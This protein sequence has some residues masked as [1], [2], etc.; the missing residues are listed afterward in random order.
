MKR[1]N[2]RGQALVEFAIVVPVF[3][4]LLAGMIQFGIILWGQNTLNQVVRD[5]GRYAATLCTDATRLTVPT[6]FGTL[7]TQ[8]G[9]PWTGGTAA[10]TYTSTSCPPDKNT[11]HWVTVVGTANAPK[12]FPWVPGNAVLT[13]STEFR[14]EP[15]P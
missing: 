1:T 7:L 8:A 9:G 11:V 12:F 3:I 15:A 13:S 4:L 6:R 10:V 2:E 14:V 5:T